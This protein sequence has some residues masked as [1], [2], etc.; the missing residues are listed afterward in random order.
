MKTLSQQETKE[1]HE[2]IAANTARAIAYL[3]QPEHNGAIIVRALDNVAWNQ[4][5][6]LVERYAWMFGK[7]AQWVEDEMASLFP[8]AGD[9]AEDARLAEMRDAARKL[10]ERRVIEDRAFEAKVAAAMRSPND[11]AHERRATGSTK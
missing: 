1:L 10:H 2:Q 9:E 11:Q 3:G 5:K 6:R 8:F 7:S 4:S